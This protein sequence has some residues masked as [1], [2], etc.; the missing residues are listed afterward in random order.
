MSAAEEPPPR[1]KPP[2]PPFALPVPDAPAV[3]DV[4]G[5]LLCSVC[6][7]RPARLPWGFCLECTEQWQI[8]DEE[9]RSQ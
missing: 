5:N 4:E 8:Y 7:Q 3:R 9:Q 6:K 2:S 1:K